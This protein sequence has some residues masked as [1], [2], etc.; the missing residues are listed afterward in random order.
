MKGQIKMINFKFLPEELKDGINQLKEYIKESFI[1]E[2]INITAER[3]ESNEIKY[4]DGIYK[5]IYQK[6]VYFFRALSLIKDTRNKLDISEP[7]KIENT[8][9]QLDLSRNAVLTVSSLKEYMD[10]MAKM[11]MNK[12]YLYMEDMFEVPE[13]KYFGYLRGRYTKEELKEIDNYGFNYGI[14]VIPSIQALG[15]HYQYLQHEES[16]DVKDTHGELMVGEEKTYLFIESM[17]KSVLEPFRTN[18]ILLGMDETHTLG[19]GNYLKK[20]GYEKSRDI[21]LK[22]LNK[23]F[24]IT[25]KLDVQAMIYSDMFFNMSSQKGYYYDKDSEITEDTISKIPENATLI[26][27]HYGEE[28]GCDD[29]MLKKHKKLKRKVIFF[30]GAWTW[31]GHL[32]ETNYALECTELALKACSKH[33]ID[34]TI[35][36]VWGDNGNECNHF[37]SLLTLCYA[38]EYSYGNEK[39]YR[40]RFECITGTSPEMFENMS[41]YQNIFDKGIE[42]KTFM[43]RFHGKTLFYQDILLGKAD[44]YLKEQPMSEHYGKYSEKFSEYAKTKNAWQPHYEYISYIFKTLEIKC[45]IAEKLRD[46]YKKQD[47]KELSKIAFL[48]K[49]DLYLFIDTCHKMHKKLWFLYN[50]PFGWEVI[51][52]RY[53]G[54]KARALTAFERIDGYLN[55]EISI[56]EELEEEILPYTFSPFIK[57]P[58]IAT[59]TYEF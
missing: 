41:A 48:L 35:I 52:I 34:E 26:Y 51:D 1:L 38:A 42:N 4:K 59:N 19:L 39:K 29:Y 27:W 24:E 53:A 20:N 46:A 28:Y 54:L 14:E 2:D 8:G 37:Y 36:T 50:K 44:L 40:K 31:S 7:S 17:I 47:K 6:K 57:Y 22:H 55:G 12:L 9:V 5:I 30:G 43:E 32:P 13:R 49:N 18:K 3:G 23:V 58:K 25:D 56:I 45:Y 10:Y 33:N 21:Y 11:G 15:H 16:F